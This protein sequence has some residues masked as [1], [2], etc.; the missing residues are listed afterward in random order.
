MACLVTQKDI[1]D[2]IK[3]RVKDNFDSVKFTKYSDR[4]AGFIPYETSNPSKNVLFGKVKNLES[5]LNKEFGAEQYNAVVSFSQKVDGV[6]FNIHPSRKLA[7]AM[8]Q[9]NANDEVYSSRYQVQ[10]ELDKELQNS[11]KP[12]GDNYTE[13][14]RYKQTQLEEIEAKRK[15]LKNTDTVESRAKLKE[16]DKIS[17][18]IS[19]QLEILANNQVDYMFHAIIDDLNSI[20][21]ALK[22]FNI[23]EVNDVKEKLDYYSE[24]VKELI[25]YGH[26]DFNEITG[27]IT[28]LLNSYDKLLDDKVVKQLEENILVQDLVTN[29]NT[30]RE[31]I[32]K[33]QVKDLLTTESDISWADKTFLGLISS[34]TNETILPQFLMS[35]FRTKLHEN[36]NNVIAL[37]DK[38]NS[39][40]KRTN[41]KDFDWVFS[42]NSK[43][44]IDGHLIDIFSKGWY[45]EFRNRNTKLKQF[46]DSL[47]SNNVDTKTTY[48]NLVNWY[49]NNTNLIDFTRLRDVK[50]IYGD[51]YSEHFTHTDEQIDSYEENIKKQLGPRYDE[52]ISQV[53]NKLQKFEELKESDSEYKERN[54]ASH[55]VWQFLKEYKKGTPGQMN[56]TYGEDRQG[57]VYFSAF[58]D[59]AILPKSKIVKTITTDTERIS[60]EKDSGFYSEEFQNILGD[61]DKVEYWTILKEMSNYINSTYNLEDQG[62][63]SYPKVKSTFNERMLENIKSVRANSKAFGKVGKQF[64]ELGHEYKAFF[65][66]Q[67]K[68]KVQEGI[69]SNYS[70]T[71]KKEIA[72]LAKVYML[73]GISRADAY[74]KATTEILKDYSTNINTVFK[75]MALEAALHETRLD[76]APMAKGV[77]NKFKKIKN[78]SGDVIDNKNS[79]QRLEYYVSKIILNQS[80]K[81]RGYSEVGGTDLSNKSMLSTINKG[82]V[83]F[84]NGKISST[85]KLRLLNEAEKKTLEELKSLQKVGYSGEFTINELGHLL[86]RV[87]DPE[88]EQYLHN[89]NG[90]IVDEEQ[91][92]KYFDKYVKDKKQSL[93]LDLNVAG[94]ID[95]T[96]KTII[97]KSLALNPISGIFNRVEGKHSAMIM[98]LTNEYWTKGN[99][100]IANQIMA[101]SNLIKILPHR[102]TNTYKEK[103]HTIE[104]F[105]LLI[106]KLGTL[107]DRKNE[108]QRNVDESKFNTE[109]L[110]LFKW[111]VER[112]EFK[113]Q[114]AIML[115]IMMD[116]K[117]KDNQG[118]EHTLLDRNTKK[119]VPFD[120]IDGVLKIKPEFEDSFS[121]QGDEM[122]KLTL[123]IEDAVSHSQGNYNQYDIMLAKKNIWGR[124]GTL[125]MT[126]FPE[127]INQ[128][129]GLRGKD[130]YNLF[131]GK[132]KKE[133]R[134]IAGYKTNKANFL[135]YI[136]ATLGISYGAMGLGGLI[137]VG[138]VGAYV[139]NKFLKKI[140]TEES[141]KRDVN[142]AQEMV[143]FLKSTLIESLNYPSRI[144]SSV[145]GLNKLQ[146][147]NNSFA[148]TNMSQEEIN[149]MQAMTRE[150]AIMLSLLAIKFAIAS[151]TY[152][153]DDDKDSERRKRHNFI[154]NQLNRGITS[155]ATYSDPK[156]LIS[157]NSRIAAITF[158]IDFEKFFEQ[159]VY[160]PKPEK[161]AD[162]FFKL[163]P[164]PRMIIKALRGEAPWEDS[165]DYSELP[166]NGLVKPLKW[167]T[168]VFKDNVT[169]GEYSAQK[170]YKKLRA[171]M[172]EE[173]KDELIDKYGNNKKVL[174]LI[175]RKKLEEK[176]GKKYKG[177]SYAEVAEDLENDVRL[178][179]P[180]KK[181]K[182]T[183]ESRQDFKDKLKEEG[184][185]GSEI[186]KI[187]AE[188][189]RER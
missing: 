115:S 13:F 34:T 38:L 127:H 85:E 171:E 77:L 159:I 45:G 63:L 14:V 24:F 181:G 20:D 92:K 108:L 93:G 32:D 33:L 106:N 126:W 4:V 96:L 128:R 180:K 116:T 169:D 143:Q 137:G 139:Y 161:F 123:K 110:N 166:G 179:D 142:Y 46:I 53:L 10:Q 97:Y 103:K 153:D 69:V 133:G 54:L 64:K 145:P 132:E 47:A 183:R 148:G 185:S 2:L 60:E 1:Q 105:E 57:K 81:Q 104:I 130:N 98:D 89:Y 112:P 52:V 65:Y 50:N 42:R 157:D 119:F 111:A 11:Q 35:E 16:L 90:N 87:L 91:F 56:Y 95:G 129:W 114:G 61:R 59:L 29:L 67:G 152:N 117:I 88:T 41:M 174:D 51:V 71:S 175:L 178:K 182:A 82:I 140:T 44:E 79:M 151:L 125:F 25:P 162:N 134:F 165:K 173:L 3:N 138:I 84:S 74:E 40:T 113:N 23:H 15:R 135:T 120:I 31:D 144:G 73:K 76:V 124:A 9:Q 141:L 72:Q 189:F 100:D 147:K 70:D 49:K 158:L 168:D 188:E 43:G 86:Q 121:L 27:K 102:L 109:S 55:D 36:Q 177:L 68:H 176:M 48:T 170:K 58:N 136:V 18:N 30:D 12:I 21:A 94:L 107:Q 80:E 146:I 160:D 83:K 26:E 164:V 155:L 172:K 163:T 8:S 75:A 156:A 78:K 101:F 99:I 184:L 122:T 150:L 149:S 28:R 66:E 19:N 131:T 62:R 17:I 5:L 22:D 154:Q 118:N 167:T 186:S 7:E 37:I 39:F 6:E 187:M